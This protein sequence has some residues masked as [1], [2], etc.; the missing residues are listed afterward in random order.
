MSVSVTIYPHK[1]TDA[2]V[3]RETI[4]PCLLLEYA[5]RQ[6]P[7]IR[8]RPVPLFT[9]ELNGVPVPFTRWHV[10]HLQ[11]GDHLVCQIEPRDPLT[12]AI[13]LSVVS[14]AA[15]V[16]AYTKA[17]NLPD[18][19]VRTVPNGSSIYRA[20]LQAN[21]AKKNGVI[22]EIAGA[23]PR[24]PDLITPIHRKYIDHE[25]W[26][27]IGLC[28]GVGEF[29]ISS[30]DIRIGE[31][32]VSNYASDVTYDLVGPGE[33]VAAI[34]AAEHWYTSR[35]IGATAGTTGLELVSSDADFGASLLWDFNATE[36]TLHDTSSPSNP[37]SWDL[38]VDDEIT[39]S[40]G[41]NAGRYRVVSIN[42]PD[43][44]ATFVK[45]HI[46]LVGYPEPEQIWEPDPTWTAFTTLSDQTI[47]ASY[48]GSTTANEWSN[49]VNILPEGET[50]DTIEI[51]VRFPRGLGH[52]DDDGTISN[53]TVELAYEYR[54]VGGSS[55]A[56]TISKTDATR[57]ERG[58]TVTLALG[59]PAIE[60]QIRF[61]RNTAETD[62]TAYLE[63]VEITRVKGQ[64]TAASSYADVTTIWFAIKATNAI[65][66]AA[67]NQ[68]NM[69]VQRK[70]PTSAAYKTWK[71][72]GYG[73]PEP[74]KSAHSQ[75]GGFILYLIQQAGY[76]LDDVDVDAINTLQATW[77]SRGDTFDAEIADES[78]LFELIRRAAA[79]GYAEP[80]IED[81]LIT[82]KRDGV[83]STYDYLYTPDKILP[84]GITRVGHLY[85]PDEPDGVEVEY[86][87]KVKRQPDVIVYRLAA[88]GDPATPIRPKKVKA[89]GITDSTKAW[90]FGS[91]ERRRQ[92][93]KPMQF[94]FSTEMDGL[95]S[96]YL[97]APAIA[98]DLLENGITGFVT[99][100][101]SGNILTL[102]TPLVFISGETHKIAISKKDGTLSGL[103]T[104][105]AGATA[106]EVQLDGALD[107]T[108]DFDGSHELPV[109]AFGTESD[110]AVQVVVRDIQPQGD[111]NVQLTCEEYVAG[112]WADIDSS[113]P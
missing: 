6:D 103:Y 8:M 75:I 54:P 65:A 41:D 113:P 27:Y 89:W 22:P 100:E 14:I 28:V 53:H 96:N 73:S 95:N 76:S 66:S 25:E 5:C 93:Y 80:T 59:S 2:D 20:D 111:D 63:D 17:T 33:S 60:P 47:D 51:D 78:T 44:I 62:D 85:D 13:V 79:V 3:E 88:A 10:T 84:P 45:M 50:T 110:W 98:D 109:F 112:I 94:N 26:I 68:I 21:A 19:A 48:A 42:S 87:D 38:A 69:D 24:F 104:A 82:L 106:Y 108:P 18:N 74:V 1:L 71:D 57:D 7:G 102:D 16:Y 49:W 43:N 11:D 67:E 90:R 12:V 35:E 58:Y 101:A 52:I 92:H 23:M 4:E 77:T 72:A 86:F 64:L 55:T 32:P 39:I 40:A 61:R 34:L 70:L 99:A 107:F 30:S 46:A 105:T 97:D 9:C 83:R 81:G 31:T 29:T 91:I 15:S 36:I 56:G 37:V